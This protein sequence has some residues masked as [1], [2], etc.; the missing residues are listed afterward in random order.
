MSNN[1][2]E[3]SG[4]GGC[5]GILVCIGIVIS[6]F[7]SCA[8]F[9]SHPVHHWQE[10]TCSAPQTCVD[11][12]A[13]KGEPLEHDL[14]EATCQRPA[15]CRVCGAEVGIPKSHTYL[16][17]TC[18][19]PERCS[20]CGHEKFFSLPNGH[21]WV[22]ATCYS[23]KT[24]TVCGETE[25][26]VQH[27]FFYSTWVVVEE[28]TCQSEGQE[29]NTCLQ[30]GSVC[31]RSIP[32][33]DHEAGEWQIIRKATSKEAGLKAHYCTMCGVELETAEIPYLN[34]SGS[35]NGGTGGNAGN[36]DN[37]NR[38][39]NESQQQTSASYVLN[40]S[41]MVFHRP[42]CRDV[43]RIAPQN[44]STSSA[45]RDSIIADGYRSCGHCNP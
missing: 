31:T 1:Q 35:G 14:I 25:G 8:S 5:L 2:K 32:L 19:E 45:S 22:D 26:D 41:T 12:G 39:N 38:Y 11:C 28:A 44:H 20:V 4:C 27:Q 37:F 33:R 36:G 3:S 43:K 13:T 7:Q 16:P 6:V 24:C 34:L 42:T 30:C 17:A 9:I 21:K 29:Q 40:T 10:A 18:T 23:P 15:V